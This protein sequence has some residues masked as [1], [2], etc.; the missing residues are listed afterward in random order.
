[1]K[2][3]VEMKKL[4]LFVLLNITIFSSYEIRDNKVYYEG[5]LLK[6]ADVESFQILSHLYAKD[7]KNVYSFGEI[8]YEFDV[9]SFEVCFT[10]GNDPT[11]TNYTKDKNSIYYLNVKLEQLDLDTFIALENYYGKDKKL[12]FFEDHLV[13]YIDTKTFI[14]Y[15]KSQIVDGIS[16]NSED[17]NNYYSFGKIVKVKKWYLD[18]YNNIFQTIL[19]RKTY[20]C[21]LYK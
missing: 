8:I 13:E 18:Y 17:K 14:S 1:M 4:I 10:L 19:L 6:N 16:Y 5:D 20:A 9:E 21:G 7:K 15:R 12:V 3:G 2:K 11:P